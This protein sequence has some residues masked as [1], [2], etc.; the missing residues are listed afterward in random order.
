[1]TLKFRMHRHTSSKRLCIYILP[2]H[3]LQAQL[4][5]CSMEGQGPYGPGPQPFDKDHVFDSEELA[6]EAE[7]Y[8]SD[9]S[10]A[11]ED[12]YK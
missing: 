12:G 1:M 6:S 2:I 10:S 9:V 5:A 7:D 4:V 11:E 8:V 3:F